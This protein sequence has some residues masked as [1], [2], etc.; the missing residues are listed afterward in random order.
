MAETRAAFGVYSFDLGSLQPD[1]PER[2]AVIHLAG[3]VVQ[4]HV[5]LQIFG[6][7]QRMVAGQRLRTADRRDRQWQQ[8]VDIEIRVMAMP[9]DD[10]DIR[11]IQ[12]VL[13]GGTLCDIGLAVNT[14]AAHAR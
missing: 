6:R 5:V 3:V 9:V 14:G 2:L 11:I 4:Q 8:F 10:R 7:A 13:D 1:I 12:P